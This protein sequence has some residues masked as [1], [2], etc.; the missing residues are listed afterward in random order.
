MG[1]GLLGA[2][3]GEVREIEIP[4]GTVHYKVVDIRR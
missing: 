2:G 4:M 3:I 1:A